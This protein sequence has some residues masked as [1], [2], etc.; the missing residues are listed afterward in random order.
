MRERRTECDGYHPETNSPVLRPFYRRLLV[1]FAHLDNK[2][3][4]LPDK[5]GGITSCVLRVRDRC[6]ECDGYHGLKSEKLKAVMGS[7]LAKLSLY[8]KP[9]RGLALSHPVTLM[10]SDGG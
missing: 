6:T 10:L 5:A 1:R 3:S 9:R 8:Q 4:G 2:L 7:K